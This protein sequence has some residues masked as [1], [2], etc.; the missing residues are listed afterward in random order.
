MV[1]VNATGVS[2]P[3]PPSP[4]P[5]D[6]G[7][8]AFLR[9]GAYFIIS[10]C[11]L[12][13]VYAQGLLF[14]EWLDVFG[15]SRAMTAGVGTTGT[16]V[17]ELGGA[18]VGA[19]I[20]RY[21]ERRCCLGGGVLAALGLLLSSWAT[22]LWHLYL[23]YSIMVGFGHSLSLF[24][25]AVLMNRWFL[26][27]RALAS[28]LGNSGSGTGTLLFGAFVPG[29]MDSIGWRGT[30]RVLALCTTM[31]CLVS[32]LLDGPPSS[33]AGNEQETQS[34]EPE[35]EPE[36]E[37]E[38]EP[39]PEAEPEPVSGSS[40]S[41]DQRQQSLMR[42]S[43][44]V[45]VSCS[46]LWRLRRLRRVMGSTF[47][48]GFGLWIP[49]YFLIKVADDVGYLESEAVC[50]IYHSV[51][52]V[53]RD[54]IRSKA[55]IAAALQDSLVTYIGV[56]SLA[57]R[58][59]GMYA[60]DIFGCRLVATVALVALAVAN[61]VAALSVETAS[62][63]LLKVLAAICGAGIGTLMSVTS[64]LVAA[65]VSMRQM[66]QAVST[67]YAC[68]AVGILLSAPIAGDLIDCPL[69]CVGRIAQ[70]TFCMQGGYPT[71]SIQWLQDFSS[72]PQLFLL[73]PLC[74]T[75]QLLT[76]RATQRKSWPRDK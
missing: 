66:P 60:A 43:K 39:E 18:A 15:E 57:V 35:P 46:E 6:G 76:L 62:L 56:G 71:C 26:K 28:G 74:C 37:P 53:L 64:P 72:L 5:P 30:M 27:R 51:I 49:A 45:V 36:P 25:G 1:G 8:A 73:R 7:T 44:H 12:G 13:V 24:S 29:T 48:Y 23:S 14:A 34:L 67:T 3:P 58:A 22:R 10:V 52:D 40:A 75:C 31:L 41:M 65:C 19:L 63:T 54:Y 59:P 69:L 11:T 50:A 61:A 16:C 20:A 47:V 21:G 38:L 42:E 32:V 4:P 2:P 70:H 9:V 33:H 68:L 17:M 55:A